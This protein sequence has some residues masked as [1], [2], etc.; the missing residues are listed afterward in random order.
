MG[1]EEQI[2]NERLRKIK[3]LREKGI[4]PYPNRYDKKQDC[5]ECL[6]SKLN[7]NVKTAGRL[8]TK[9]NLGKIAFAKI[10]DD[11]ES[12]QIVLQDGKTP[13]K[14]FEFFK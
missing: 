9:R 5:L 2:I 4:N 11:T 3:E 6:K 14:S 10:R 8:M 7:S 12:I 13:E 1:R